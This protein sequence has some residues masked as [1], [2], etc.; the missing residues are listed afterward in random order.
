MH[1]S[2]S[3]NESGQ[4]SKMS[5]TC[6]LNALV[7]TAVKLS[8]DDYTFPGIGSLASLPIHFEH[9]FTNT[10]CVFSV[11]CLFSITAVSKFFSGPRIRFH[12]LVL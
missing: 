1:A 9:F 6:S 11:C 8:V 5:L 3:G 12:G 4:F 10:G 7:L 2:P